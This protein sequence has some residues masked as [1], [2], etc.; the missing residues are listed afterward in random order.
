[1]G[2]WGGQGGLGCRRLGSPG[3]AG[4]PV[5]FSQ[6]PVCG[7]RTGCRLGSSL[8][9]PS[10]SLPEPRGQ[11]PQGPGPSGPTDLPREEPHL[12]QAAPS[13]GPGGALW[14]PTPSPP[15][16]LACHLSPLLVPEL[17][18][19][20]FLA[21]T[22]G[23]WFRECHAAGL[24]FGL[25]PGTTGCSSL[26]CGFQHLLVASSSWLSRLGTPLTL[27]WWRAEKE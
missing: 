17:P 3:L 12:C 18:D 2:F 10:S 14:F 23:G 16:P 7:D 26:L 15:G 9:N 13:L 1:M 5:Q 8:R 22:V 6:A 25:S 27:L 19:P 4:T 11:G 20:Q 24:G 21:L